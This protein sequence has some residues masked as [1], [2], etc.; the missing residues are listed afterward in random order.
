LANIVQKKGE[1]LQKFIQH[2]CNKRNIIPEVD[3][4]SIIMFLKKGLRDSSLIHKL[5]KK[6]PRTSEEMLAI[7]NKYALA[8]EVKE[9]SQFNRPGT[10]TSNNKK[11]KSDR[12]VANVE[13]LHDNRTE[14]W[15]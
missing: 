9:S 7:T 8:E 14:Y 10:S 13:W 2:F 4:M 11:R 12:C 6:N 5:T 1:S 3:N 15:P